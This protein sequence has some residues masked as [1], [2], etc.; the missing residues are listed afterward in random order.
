MIKIFKYPLSLESKFTLDLPKESKILSVQVQNLVPVLWAFVDTDIHE[1]EPKIFRCYY[2]G[3]N[4]PD[5]DSLIY[6]DTMQLMGGTL[7][8]H[9][10]MEK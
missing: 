9:I 7:V 5:S 3:E 10:F 2:T 1:K 4:I 8:A 6:L